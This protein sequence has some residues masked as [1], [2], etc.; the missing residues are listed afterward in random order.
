MKSM[1]NEN[2]T[3]FL[4]FNRQKIYASMMKTAFNVTLSNSASLLSKIVSYSLDYN[5]LSN[6]EVNI[7][8]I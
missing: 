6:Q 7:T 2:Y 3:Y 1:I 5:L 4:P 8:Q